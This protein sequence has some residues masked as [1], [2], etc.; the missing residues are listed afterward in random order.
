M[1]VRVRV[2]VRVR[3]RCKP[4]AC[5]AGATRARRAVAMGGL[6]PSAGAQQQKQQQQQRKN[7]RKSEAA[8]AATR[9]QWAQEQQQ[10]Q[11]Q[12]REQQRATTGAIALARAGAPSPLALVHNANTE[13]CEVC[14]RGERLRSPM[15][16]PKR[17][18]MYPLSY[19]ETV[20]HNPLLLLHIF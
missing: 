16:Q 2:R 18:M 1:R 7:H 20:F 15:R 14:R 9:E 5:L 13:R 17:S 4:R 6:H 10:Q 19:T 12:Q 11:K 3:Y 8:K